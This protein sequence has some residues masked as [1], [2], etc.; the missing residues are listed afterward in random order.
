MEFVIAHGSSKFLKSEKFA[1]LKR[2]EKDSSP[3]LFKRLTVYCLVRLSRKHY[4]LSDAFQ[5]HLLTLTCDIILKHW[6]W[7]YPF[8]GRHVGR[9]TYRSP[10]GITWV[11]AGP[12]TSCFKRQFWPKKM[13]SFYIWDLPWQKKL[14]ARTSPEWVQRAQGLSQHHRFEDRP[15]P[16]KTPN[17][18]KSIRFKDSLYFW[19]LKPK[20]HY[21]P[22]RMERD[23]FTLRIS[24]SP[25]LRGIDLMILCT[26]LVILVELTLCWIR[27]KYY[28]AGVMD[29][30]M[31]VMM[32]KIVQTPH[33]HWWL[34]ISPLP[35]CFPP[36][37]HT[38]QASSAEKAGWILA[39]WGFR[40]PM[41][42]HLSGIRSCQ[43]PKAWGE[44]R[45]QTEAEL[46]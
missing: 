21:H 41:S 36:E 30:M 32:V 7:D 39:S 35:A 31:L 29:L 37:D 19:T 18:I 4:V 42:S 25:N 16:W 23:Y 44:H 3:V 15:G 40:L 6:S 38:P 13:S 8:A 26:N 10:F 45:G 46:R 12:R 11:W 5:I 20:N 28:F 9:V 1:A 24:Q 34:P 14:T 22:E 17:K 33:N 43:D 2:Q 27:S